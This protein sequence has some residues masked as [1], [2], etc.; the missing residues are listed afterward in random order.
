MGENG[1]FFPAG[2]S[3]AKSLDATGTL[4]SVEAHPL[5]V[6][7]ACAT[8]FRDAR[9]HSGMPQMGGGWLCGRLCAYETLRGESYSRRHSQ[10]SIQ[11]TT[12]KTRHARFINFRSNAFRFGVAA[13]SEIGLTCRFEASQSSAVD[14][15]DAA[16]PR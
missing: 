11:D 2:E 4:S 12:D 5:S 9:P 10:T 6:M 16:Y 14:R 7:L 3:C 13:R 8:I 15:T 1:G